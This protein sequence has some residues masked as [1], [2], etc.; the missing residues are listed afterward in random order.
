M[1]RFFL[2]EPLPG[3]PRHVGAKLRAKYSKDRLRRTNIKSN[4]TPIIEYTLKPS[5][6]DAKP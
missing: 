2:E 6:D 1:T 5:N 3:A 4:L